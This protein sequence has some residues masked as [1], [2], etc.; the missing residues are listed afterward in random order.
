[1]Y[2]YNHRKQEIETLLAEVTTSFKEEKYFSDQ[3]DVTITALEINMQLQLK[4]MEEQKQKFIEEIKN[5][6][7]EL[8]RWQT[9]VERYV[10]VYVYT[11][12]CLYI[13]MYICKYKHIY[14]EIH[15]IICINTGMVVRK[16]RWVSKQ[17]N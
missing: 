8:G 4:K 14:R 9:D 15:I 6:T 16:L 7:L 13:Y 3:K 1:M 2:T 12:I 10:Y 5:L 11:Y 17:P